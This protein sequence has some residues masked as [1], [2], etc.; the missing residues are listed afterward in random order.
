MLLE[1]CGG[2]LDHADPQVTA[3]H[4][5]QEELGLELGELELVFGGYSTPGAVCEKVFYYI[6]PYTPQQR[7][8]A[9]GGNLH[10]GEDIEVIEMPLADAVES[11]HSG[12]IQD[13]RTIALVLHLALHL[14]Q[15]PGGTG[16]DDRVR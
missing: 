5:A 14:A 6:A 16:G 10:E 2:I 8:H 13:V 12:A 9:G 4:E 3:R 7:L 11:I 1:V 15:Q